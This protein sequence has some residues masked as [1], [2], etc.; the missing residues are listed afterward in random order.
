M[1]ARALLAG[2][3]AATLTAPVTFGQTPALHRVM[4]EKLDHAQRILAAVVT[5]D[6]ATLERESGELARAA[7]DPAWTVLK[8]PEYKRESDAFLRATRDLLN[9]AK[10]HDLDAA[11][12]AEIAL[13]TSCVQCHRYVARQRVAR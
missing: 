7:D 10:Q 6:W 8:T 13:T 2:A 1:N 4:R 12:T 11:S 3:L 9:A 5:S